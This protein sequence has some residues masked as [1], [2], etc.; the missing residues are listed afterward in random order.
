MIF[1]III[2]I[3]IIIIKTMEQSPSWE[4]DSHSASYYRLHEGSTLVPNLIQIHP[5]PNLPPY[6]SKIHSNIILLFMCRSPKWSLP[7]RFSN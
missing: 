6:F 1:I 3:I 2:I 4:F 7:F 5:I